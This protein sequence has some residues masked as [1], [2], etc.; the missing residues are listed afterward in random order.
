MVWCS[1]WKLASAVAREGGLGVIGS[2]SMYPEILEE[3][4]TKIKQAGIKNFAVNLPLFYPQI[5]EHLALIRIHGVQTV[6]TS[7]GNPKTYTRALQ[8]QGCKVFHVVAN[9]KFTLKALEAGVDGIIAE[10]FEA[11]GHNGK[12]ELTTF[13]LI[14][15]LRPLIKNIPLVAAGGIAT[16]QSIYAAMALGADGVQIGTR[17]AAS[18]ESSAH[19][20]FKEAIVKAGDGDTL[21][22]LKEITPVRLLKTPFFHQVMEAYQRGASTE[23]LRT[24]LGKGRAKKGIFEGNWEEGE[25]EMGQVAGQINRIE[26][27]ENIFKTLL[28]ELSATQK[29]MEALSLGF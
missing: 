6:I 4:L 19:R 5:E 27:V 2:G 21:L 1:G 3:H 22:T 25:F 14:P 18:K 16:G 8:E 24:L 15:Q 11:G 13:T 9:S 10:G 17:F 7:A 29:R 12:D 20:L 26:T 28:R 23:E